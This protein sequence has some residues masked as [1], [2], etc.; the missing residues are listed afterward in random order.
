MIRWYMYYFTKKKLNLWLN[1]ILVIT[2]AFVFS[3]V[4][5]LRCSPMIIMHLLYISFTNIYGNNNFMKTT[6]LVLYFKDIWKTQKICLWVPYFK[7][8]IAKP[9]YKKIVVFTK[10][11]WLSP[12]INMRLKWKCSHIIWH[13][14]HIT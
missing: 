11:Y 12:V 10:V 13:V 6:H 5:T 9:K 14:G 8:H 7:L 3:L 4:S 1:E 2:L